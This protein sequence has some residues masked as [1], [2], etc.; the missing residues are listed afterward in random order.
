ML[1]MALECPGKK[2]GA[3]GQKQAQD[4]RYDG[5]RPRRSSRPP[6]QTLFPEGEV[7][8]YS[9]EIAAKKQAEQQEEKLFEDEYL[10]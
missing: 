3:R 8:L 6:I 1:P 10:R 4:S 5:Q 9:E 2:P 7:L